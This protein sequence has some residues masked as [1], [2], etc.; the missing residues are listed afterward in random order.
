MKKIHLLK[1]WNTFDVSK[2]LKHIEAVTCC[3]IIFSKNYRIGDH[4]TEDKNKVT[5]EICLIYLTNGQ[6]SVTS[7]LHR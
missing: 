7:D 6:K 1:K 5:C 4:V 3:D 2:K